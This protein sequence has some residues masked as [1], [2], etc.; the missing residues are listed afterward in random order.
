MSSLFAVST[1]AAADDPSKSAKRPKRGNAGV[2]ICSQSF[3]AT[4]FLELLLSC[5]RQE[6]ESALGG[7]PSLCFHRSEESVHSQRWQ[8]AEQEGRV[9]RGEASLLILAK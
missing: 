2:F 8:K 3:S 7:N 6:V 5:P 4:I 1:E 9:V